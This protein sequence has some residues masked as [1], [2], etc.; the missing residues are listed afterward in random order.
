[1]TLRARLAV[2]GPGLLVAATGVGA[3]DLATAAFAGNK[4]G[5]VIL[6]AVLFGSV[7][8]FVLNEGIA[9]WQL[10]TGET[11]LEGA[12]SRFG[13]WS[14]WVFL[15][16]LVIWSFFVGSALIG[17]C[18]VAANALIPIGSNP[19]VGKVFWGLLH[20]AVGVVLVR[21]GG[22]RLFEKVMA[23]GIGVMFVTVT[24]TA[25]LTGPDWAAVIRGLFVPSLPSGGLAWTVALIGGVGGTVT[26]LC[27]G[28]WIREEGRTGAED[29][30]ACR[31]D[32]ASGYVMT[33]VF[34]LAMVVIGST[35]AID[36][37]GVGLLAALADRLGETLGGPG[38]FLFLIGAWAAIASSLLGVWQSV[39]YLF[40]DTWNHGVV[41]DTASP[42]YRG[43]LYALATIPAVGLF[44][45]FE[46]AQKLYAIVGAS[47]MPMLAGSLLWLN[48]REEWVG[49]KLKNGPVSN[50]ALLLVLG[51]FFFAAWIKLWGQP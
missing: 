21:A 35:T 13:V 49:P 10:G 12:F 6:W 40:S 7:L 48:G 34:G 46:T 5:V 32:L 2:L 45:S 16:Y 9:R 23:V 30:N 28:Y 11:L 39:P 4:F 25:V 29:L 36:G 24:L 8:K 3:G 47:F 26:V 37:K 20:S 51:F 42:A 50:L 19:F 43:Y 14:R 31:W 41:V 15:F 1:M 22:Y 27:Y 44:M 18:G 38:R 33:A 17:A